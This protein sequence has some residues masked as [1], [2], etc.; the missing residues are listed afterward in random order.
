MQVT[1][2]SL[3]TYSIKKLWYCL[4][5][6]NI[7]LS[8]N[9]GGFLDAKTKNFDT[10]FYTNHFRS[11]A[12]KHNTHFD[13]TKLPHK[14]NEQSSETRSWT[15]FWSMFVKVVPRQVFLTFF[16]S[17]HPHLVKHNNLQQPM[18]YF[19]HLF[20]GTPMCRG[21]ESMTKTNNIHAIL[22]NNLFIKIP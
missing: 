20:W 12:V 8:S 7:A 21:F 9:S 13:R 2:Y 17:R 14:L 19:W 11:S 3:F 4:D 1:I 5:I 22:L 10:H 18:W 6:F 15:S 16:C